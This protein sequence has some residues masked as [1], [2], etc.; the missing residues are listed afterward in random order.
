MKKTVTSL[1]S[2]VKR[3]AN[4]K[5]TLY[6]VFAIALA[7]LY[8]ILMT[9]DLV[10]LLVFIAA[11]L[12]A[13]LYSANMVA[14]LIFAIILSNIAKLRHR[15]TEGFE[16]PEEKSIEKSRVVMSNGEEPDTNRI[17][18]FK[19]SY[20]E[21]MQLQNDIMDGIERVNKPLEKAESIMTGLKESMIGLGE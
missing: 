3:M 14:V 1:I 11:G 7:N 4:T 15:D 5:A 17:E 2:A 12:L 6:I 19:D 8:G 18:K 9:N 21:L 10:T 16:E 13:S 20:K